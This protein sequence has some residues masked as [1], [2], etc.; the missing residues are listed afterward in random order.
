MPTLLEPLHGQTEV[1]GFLASRLSQYWA[2]YQWR[3]ANINGGPGFVMH[4]QGT[5]TAVV[6]FGFDPSGQATDIFIV[7]NPDKLARLTL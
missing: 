4:R 5:V 7:R 6:T 1:L 2:D 3:E